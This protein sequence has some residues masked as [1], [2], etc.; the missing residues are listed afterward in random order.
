MEASAARPAAGRSA[1]AHVSATPAT[2]PAKQQKVV[3]VSKLKKTKNQLAF[4]YRDSDTPMSVTRRTAKALAEALGVDETQMVHLAIRKL[5]EQV[6]PQYPRDDGP[7]T[8]K[9]IAALRRDAQERLPK[10]KTIS[11]QSLFA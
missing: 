2:K 5:A 3:I 1:R 7:L 9:Q 6:L 11:R 4:R 10:G 8:T